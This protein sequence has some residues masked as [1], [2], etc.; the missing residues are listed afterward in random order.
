[1]MDPKIVDLYGEYLQERMD[2]REFLKKLSILAGGT[3]AANALLPF[4]KNSEAQGAI[5]PK[6]DPRLIEE[7]VKYSGATGEIR[8]D[9]ARPKGDEKL[10]GVVVI[11]EIRALDPHIED[12]TRR[13]ALEG[14]LAMAPDALSPVGGTPEN[15]DQAVSFMRNLDVPSTIKDYLAA[16]R[17]LKSH[18]RSTGKVGCIG[19]CWGGGMANQLAVNAPDLTAV[20]PFYGMQPATE[21]V[22]KIKA[23][24]LIH[25]A[26]IDERINKGIP[27]FEEALKKASIDYKIYMYPD[28]KH[29]FLNDTN[30]GRYNKEAAQLAWRR[31]V[32]FLK[33]KLKK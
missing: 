22:P 30:P 10:P 14:F 2:R 5:V 12:V 13:V 9:F 27:A 7:Y 28:A 25:Y 1:M 8:A 31:T 15:P 32:A 11:H 24:L 17:Y 6:G 19:F 3:A 26:G 21:D 4:L 20:V 33:E 16:V 29:A 23:S 18:P